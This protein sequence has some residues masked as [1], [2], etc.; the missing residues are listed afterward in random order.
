M[1]NQERVSLVMLESA[2]MHLQ[3]AN[4]R[5]TIITICSLVCM[6]LMVCFLAY[7]FTGFEINTEDVL[8]DSDYGNANYIGNDGDII[9][10]ESTCEENN[11][12]EE[13]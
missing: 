9:N 2:M 10:G 8:I 6:M 7:L 4:K 3:K 1:D 11:D 5:L 13:K 12:Q